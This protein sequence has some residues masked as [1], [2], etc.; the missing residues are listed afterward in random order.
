METVRNGCKDNLLEIRGL[1]VEFPLFNGTIHA[2]NHVDF[3]VPRYSVTALVGESG[4]GKS[5]MASAILNMVSTPGRI[6]EGEILVNGKDILAMDKKQLRTYKWD[7]VAMVFQAAQNSLNPLF[8]IREQMLETIR[9]HRENI[10]AEEAEKL[11]VKLLE[12]VRLDA[13]RVL[14]CYP[15]EL[16]GG[17]KQRV[18]IAFSMLLS[19]QMIILDEPSTALDVITQDYIFDILAKIHEEMNLTMLLLTHDIAIVAKVAERMCV[20]YAGDIAESGDVY[21][22]FQHPS[23]PYTKEL[24]GAAPSL[25]GGLEERTGSDGSPPDLIHLPQGCAFYPRCKTPL[26]QCQTQKPPCV[27]L[28]NGHCI[29]C[30]RYAKEGTV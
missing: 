22:I 13:A 17:M 20:M 9:V 18:M 10:T 24:I 30:H 1:S 26:P 21:T 12:Y 25:L 8:T 11:C 5:T 23:H 29:K 14:G 27:D 3:T 15:H 28:G 7:T 2:V 16:S 19:P 4:S 6:T